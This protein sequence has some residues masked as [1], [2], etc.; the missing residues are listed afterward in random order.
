[1]VGLMLF[2]GLRSGEVR[3]L[4]RD[5]LLL[6]EAQLRVH[7]KGGKPRCARNP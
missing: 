2:D 4:N 5:D 3:A 7:G 1:M 6:S